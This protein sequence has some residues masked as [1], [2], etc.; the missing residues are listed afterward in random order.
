M[1]KDPVVEHQAECPIDQ[2]KLAEYN[3]KR[4]DA[5]AKKVLRATLERFGLVEPIVVNRPTMTIINGHQKLEVWREMGH[6]T[7]PVDFVEVDETEE[8]KA[9]LDLN[10]PNIEGQFETH[11]LL[12]LQERLDD[13]FKGMELGLIG[14]GA[15]RSEGV[16]SLQP[17]NPDGLDTQG[18]LKVFRLHFLPDEWAAFEEKGQKIMKEH[19][20]ESYSDLVL[21]LARNYGV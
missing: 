3:P 4:L 9:N 8:K 5:E 16:E 6:T 13:K 17:A 2:I 1:I 7:I 15:I 18:Y 19:Q 11:L 14:T 20:M 21:W 10:N 12:P